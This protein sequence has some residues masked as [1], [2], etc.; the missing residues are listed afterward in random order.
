MT[1]FNLKLQETYFKQGFFNVIVDFDR[2]VRAE[3]G[4]IWLRL[5]RNGREIQASINRHAN[6]N[7]T[8][9]IIG[10]AEKIFLL[11]VV[12]RIKHQLP[13]AELQ[14]TSELK[15][16]L[17]AFS[18]AFAHRNLRFPKNKRQQGMNCRVWRL[19]QGCVVDPDLRSKDRHAELEHR[20]GSDGVDRAH[21]G[22]AAE[23]FDDRHG[24]IRRRRPIR[25]G[26]EVHPTT[27]C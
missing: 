6:N 22:P 12:V 18:G 26:Q 2:F 20:L 11:L 4:P 13:R 27:T 14:R 19:A 15:N 9:R 3:E 25:W 8:A 23:C 17:S 24:G 21:D 5:G 16:Q 7:G 10:G 1:V